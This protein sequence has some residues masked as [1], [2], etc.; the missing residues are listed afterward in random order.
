MSTQ[1]AQRLAESAL[2]FYD[3]KIMPFADTT[4][5]FAFGLT[6]NLEVAKACTDQVFRDMA[7]DLEGLAK[8]GQGDFKAKLIARCWQ[9][10]SARASEAA[11]SGH[12]TL[13]KALKS[14]SIDQRAALMGADVIGLAPSDAA[15]AFGWNESSLRINLAQA[16]KVMLQ[17]G[18]EL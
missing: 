2:N 15:A 8:Q 3:E 6:L 17:E 18:C 9:V 4:F 7:A 13:V 14:L 16:R 12:S 5:R 11:A 1:P 10:C